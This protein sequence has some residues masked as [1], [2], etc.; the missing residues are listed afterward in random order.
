[1]QIATENSGWVLLRHCANLGRAQRVL[2]ELKQGRYCAASLTEA[3]KHGTKIN[4]GTTASTLPVGIMDQ[5]RG[6]APDDLSVPELSEIL[7]WPDNRVAATVKQLLEDN[8][9]DRV[10][11]GGVSWYSKQGTKPRAE[12]FNRL[13]I[14]VLRCHH[15]GIGSMK[16]FELMAVHIPHNANDQLKKLVASGV[17]KETNSS[18]SL[19][20]KLR[21]K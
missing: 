1:V 12:N 13:I 14:D 17:L 18:K 15:R 21:H 9:I 19:I 20:Y 4:A 3:L 2:V 10:I 5:L 8:L 11:R 6:R 16:L 7:D